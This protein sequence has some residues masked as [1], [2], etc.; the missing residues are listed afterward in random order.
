MADLLTIFDRLSA[1]G[2]TP[3]IF[4]LCFGAEM[5]W[6]LLVRRRPR[7]AV[8]YY[9]VGPAAEEVPRI[10]APVYAVYAEDDSRV[11]ATIAEL[12]QALM[13]GRHDFV[14][15]S[16]PGTKHAFH[17]KTRPE[18]YHPEAAAAVWER[19]LRYLAELTTRPI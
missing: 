19:T 9:G 18:R 7:A 14:M 5:G 17:N 15:E 10:S 2:A 13:A 12:G 11:N 3:I 6:Q 1:E 8:L 4:G 16:Y